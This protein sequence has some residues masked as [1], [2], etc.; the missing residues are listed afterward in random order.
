M[1]SGSYFTPE[2]C[3]LALIDE[4][5]SNANQ[6]NPD[7]FATIRANLQRPDIRAAANALLYVDLGIDST[8]FPNDEQNLEDIPTY[9]LASVF[10]N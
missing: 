8:L 5:L 4:A 10:P 9:E 7:L 2:S 1:A 3:I 6:G